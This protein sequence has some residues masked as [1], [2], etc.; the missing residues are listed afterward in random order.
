[1]PLILPG[2]V[3]S[4]TAS[5][6]YTVDNSCRYND[7]D[8]PRLH[9]ASLG[10]ATDVDKWTFSCWFKRSTLSSSQ[11]LLY[12]YTSGEEGAILLNSSD[13]LDWYNYPGSSQGQLITNRKFRDVGAW[14]NL[15][16]AHDSDNGTA[17]NRMRIYINGTEETSFST[18][19]NP[20]LD[21][22]TVINR[23]LA[24]NIGLKYS[25]AIQNNF[26]GY[27]AEVCF[28]DGQQLTPSSFGEFDEDSPTIW[29]PIDVS[30]LTFGDN[31]FYFPFSD[32]ADLGADSSGNSNDFTSTNLDATDQATD[33]PTNNFAT[34]NSLTK[35]RHGLSEGNCQTIPP[36]NG[37]KMYGYT[38]IAAESGK[39]Y[40]EMEHSTNDNK[41]NYGIANVADAEEISRANDTSIGGT[42]KGVGY[43]SSSG[44]IYENGS[45]TAHGSALSDNDIIGIAMDLDNNKVYFSING[46]WQNSA[47]PS[48][49]TN[50]FVYSSTY[51]TGQ[52]VFCCGDNRDVGGYDFVEANFGGCSAFTVSSANQDGNGYG[53][54]EY[55]VPTGF[56]ALCTKNLAEFG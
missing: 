44:V 16:C 33:T 1:M 2:N 53:N 32:S 10:T 14:Y 29:K 40:C 28:I 5:T 7:G 13:C 11:Y 31:G 4:A 46:T 39:W 37:Y 34:F 43:Y 38:T 26:D 52:I 45:T 30:G 54:F 35:T 8:S 48:A 20:T 47:D 18:D 21:E 42:G 36:D 24:H 17:G 55:A 27:L 3:A 15:I 9:I 22:N 6:G 19:T 25:D 51:T 50:A 12:A 23:D 49:G 41:T 56:Y